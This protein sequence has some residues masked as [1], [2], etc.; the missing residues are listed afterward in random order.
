MGSITHNSKKNANANSN[1]NQPIT[2]ELLRTR[3][4]EKFNNFYSRRPFQSLSNRDS[5]DRVVEKNIHVTSRQQL[6]SGASFANSI[7]CSTNSSVVLG[8]GY[9]EP[10]AKRFAADHI[11]ASESPFESRTSSLHS[12]DAPTAQS[13]GSSTT[14]LRHATVGDSRN[15]AQQNFGSNSAS[16]ESNSRMD[17]SHNGS[18]KYN[19]SSSFSSKKGVSEYNHGSLNSNRQVSANAKNYATDTSALQQRWMPRS[20]PVMNNQSK[21]FPKQ[22]NRTSSPL[23]S[24]SVRSS[25]FRLNKDVMGSKA[26][27]TPLM[28]SNLEVPGLSTPHTHQTIT[29]DAGKISARTPFSG[30]TPK[31]RKFPGP[32]GL[33]PKLSPGQNLDNS[34]VA[35]PLP[36]LRKKKTPIENKVQASRPNSLEDEDF[37]HDPWTFMH[38]EFV[39]NVPMAMR[40]TIIQVYSEA[41]QQRLRHGKVP[42]LCALVKAFSLTEADASVLLRDPTGEIYGTLH[43]KVLE[44]YQTELA[45]GAGLIL[46]HV[47]VFSPAPR[48]HYLNITPGNILQIYPPDPQYIISNSQALASQCTQKENKQDQQRIS[49]EDEDISEKAECCTSELV[50]NSEEKT[51]ET[52]EHERIQHDGFDDLLEGLDDDED[53]LDEA[54]LL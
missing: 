52:T 11:S 21:D 37:N 26:P 28:R 38:Q 34:S 54:L 31:A 33:L 43:R 50:N 35:S 41:I 8:N 27:E 17:L 20:S 30:K 51:T 15:F 3:E 1:Q 2:K 4:V 5:F 29:P 49:I 32:A 10:L 24:Q 25:S 7:D 53:F 6:R 40:Y 14:F 44:N 23:Y 16:L 48:K 13:M 9:T 22:V 18:S 39:K 45:P 12:G 47:S 19:L 36:S 42:C 46:K